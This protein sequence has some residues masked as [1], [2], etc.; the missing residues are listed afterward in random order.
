MSESPE[1]LEQRARAVLEALA[2]RDAERRE[3]L[4][5]ADVEIHTG[6][7]TQRGVAA[8]LAWATKEFDHLLRTYV[9]ERLLAG[10]GSVLALGEVHYLWKEDGALADRSPI[11][12][13]LVFRGEALVALI[14]HD[15]PEDARRSFRS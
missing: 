2:A 3:P 8:A 13:E 14:L 5:A 4:L 9:A 1:H 11:A 10:E 6:R 12:L 7:A 15:D